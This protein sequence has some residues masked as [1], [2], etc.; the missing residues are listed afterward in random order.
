MNRYLAQYHDPDGSWISF[1]MEA[2]D[3]EEAVRWV[4]ANIQPLGI[5]VA[6]YIPDWPGEPEEPRARKWPYTELGG[7]API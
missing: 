4:K 6:Q 7:W 2:P 1:G 3:I 5:A